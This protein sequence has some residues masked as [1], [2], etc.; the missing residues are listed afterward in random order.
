[1]L[2]EPQ[3]IIKKRARKIYSALKKSIAAAAE[4]EILPDQSRAGG[5]SLPETDFPTFVVSIR[6]LDISVNALEKKLRLGTPPVIA[7]IK[8]NVLLIDAR[9]VQDKEVKVLVSCVVAALII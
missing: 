7:R 9:T 1:M 2:T 4:L 3:G 8:E 5:G 6:P